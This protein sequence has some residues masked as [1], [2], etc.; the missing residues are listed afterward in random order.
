MNTRKSAG[1][2]LMVAFA[3]AFIAWALLAPPAMPAMARSV[4][5]GVLALGIFLAWRILVWEKPRS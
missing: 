2:A 1:I 4:V 3:G 5:S